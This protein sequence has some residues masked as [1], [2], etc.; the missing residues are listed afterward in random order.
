MESSGSENQLPQRDTR[1]D[2]DFSDLL[3]EMSR[4]SERRENLK[5]IEINKIDYKSS[6]NYIIEEKGIFNILEIEKIKNYE[7][8]IIDGRLDGY[9]R[10]LFRENRADV[11]FDED[12]D[13]IRREQ[14]RVLPIQLL[15]VTDKRAFSLHGFSASSW[16]VIGLPLVGGELKVDGERVL[17][18]N[19]YTR[20]DFMP[21][22]RARRKASKI[23]NSIASAIKGLTGVVAAIDAREVD[24]EPI[25]VG[26]TNVNMA[27]ISQR[28][29]FKIIDSCRNPD[30][31][32]DKSR[33]SF[34]VV[35]RLEDIRQKLSEFAQSGLDQRILQ[36]DKVE[37]QKQTLQPAR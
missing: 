7:S 17:V 27:L 23:T 10:D 25:F 33:I 30:G 12:L 5:L 14:T 1:T 6:L 22:G 3:R 32:I 24:L 15:P 26:T 34:I 31:T 36:R 11:R 13:R 37:K 4:R 8:N 18:D 9:V 16:Q 35:G 21:E 20:I 2:S 29:G 19:R 28:L